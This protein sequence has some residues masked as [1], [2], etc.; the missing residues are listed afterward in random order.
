MA[1][2]G[3]NY[4][5]IGLKSFVKRPK[6]YKPYVKSIKRYDIMMDLGGHYTLKTRATRETF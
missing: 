6:M 3:F 2:L 1:K 5:Q 4:I